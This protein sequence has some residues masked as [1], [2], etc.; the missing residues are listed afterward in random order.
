MSSSGKK[1]VLLLLLFGSL[2]ITN[3]LRF[4]CFE[5]FYENVKLQSLVFLPQIE[6][7]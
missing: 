7:S 6:K 3:I 2:F 4:L 1:A 5:S